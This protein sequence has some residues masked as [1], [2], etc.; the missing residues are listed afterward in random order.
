[1]GTREWTGTGYAWPRALVVMLLSI[2]C[3]T[4]LAASLDVKV[5]GMAPDGSATEIRDYRWTIE[6]DL[7]KASVP[8]QHATRDNY[9][10]STHT[11][12][13]PLVATGKM[14]ASGPV[15]GNDCSDPASLAC[16][17]P[18]RKYMPLPD[19]GALDPAGR[20]YISVLP[21]DGYAMGGA[22]I[23]PGDTSVTVYVNKYPL[24]AAQLSVFVFNDNSPLN[25]AP[26]LPQEQGLAGFNIL[27]TE[28][29]G[30]YGA[31]GGQVTQDA[32]GNPLG[33]TYKT[34][35]SSGE[36]RVDQYCY[37]A[38]GKPVVAV[39]GTG[40]IRSGAD[41]VAVIRNLYPAKYTVQVIP[42]AGTDWKQTSTIEGTKGDD[43]WVKNGE[44]TFFQEYGPPGHHVFTGF[45]HAGILARNGNTPVL[46]GATSITGRVVSIH[47]ARPPDYSFHNGAPIEKCWVG[48]NESTGTRRALYATACNPD[49]TFTIPKVPPGTWELVVWDEPMDVII[50]SAPVTV[51]ANTPTVN[52]GDVPVFRW[53]GRYEGR[54]FFDTN[55]DGFPDANETAGLPNQVMNI[56]FRDGSIYQSQITNSKGEFVFT[57]VFP[58]FNWMIA[59]V[60]YGRF[61]ATGAT[62][63]T[64]AGGPVAPHNGWTA[65]SWGKL[66]PQTQTCD[67][68]DV[69]ANTAGSA[70]LCT[71]VGQTK[72]YRVEHGVVLLEGMQLFLGQTNHIEFGKKQYTGAENGGIAG[73]VQYGITR[74]EDDPKYATAENWEPGVPRVQV[75]LYLDCDGDGKPDKPSPAGDGTCAADGLS[76]NGYVYDPPDVDNYPFCWSDPASCGLS[77]PTRGPEDVKRSATGGDAF[78]YGDVFR[79]GLDP[80]TGAPYVGLSTSDAWDDNVPTGCPGDPYLVPYGP[81]AGLPLDCYDG[82][83]NW[84]Q[85]RP[86]VFD[87]GYAFGSVAGQDNLPNVKYIVEV[88]APPGYIHQ[89][90]GDKN[91]VFGDNLT[92]TPQAEPF[93]CVGQVLPVPQ[94]LT[95]FPEQQIPNPNYKRP[96]QTWNKC[97]MKQ[98]DMQPGRNPAP[99]FFLFTEVPVA[100]HGV[101]FILD[102][103]SSEFDVNA[104]TFGEKHA[105]PHLPVSVQD[106]TGR[107]IGRVY[108]DEF[109]LFNYLV[110]STFTINPPFPSGVSPS[111]LTA[112]MNSP[113]PIPDPSGATNADGSPKLIMDPW[114]DRRYSQFCYTFQY[115]PGKTTYLDTPV[116]PVAAFPGPAQN[117]VDCEF[118]DGVPMIYSV[119]GNNNSGPWVAGSGTDRRLTIVSAGSAVEVLNPYYDPADP[120]SQRTIRRDF[121]FGPDGVTGNSVTLGNTVLPVLSW[122]NDLITVSVPANAQ[123]G[124]L[125]VTRAGVASPVGITVT[126]GGTA[127]KYVPAGGSIQAVIDAPSTNDGDLVIVPPGIYT[128]P[129]IMDKKIRLQGWGAMSTMLNVVKSA[130][131]TL[132]NWRSLLA[133]KIDARPASPP[134]IDPDTGLNTIV[135]GPNRTFD[136]LPGQNLGISLSNNEPL[137]FGAEEAPG[138][139]VVGKTSAN[140]SG[141]GH[142]NATNPARID[143]LSI[144]G[145]DTGGGILVS[146]YGRNV[147]ISNNRIFGNAG[148]YGGGI[149]IGHSELLDANNVGYG[150]YTDSVDPNANIH[151]NWVAQ[152]GG[153]ES[154]VGGGISLG[155]GA[156]NYQVT[157]NYVCGNFTLGD[158]GGI[159]QRG[160]ADGGVIA[161][162]DILFNQTY[163]QSANPTGGGIF[164]GGAPAPDA[165]GMS[166]G[167]GS[168]TITRNLVQGNNAG[169]GVGGGIRLAQVNGLDVTR[170]PNNINSWNRVTLTNNIIVDNVAGASA[171]GVSLVDALRVT[172]VNN[173]VAFN[174]TTAT[175]QQA[176][177][178]PGANASQPQPAGLVSEA[179]SP[180]LLAA[181]SSGLRSQH[182]FSNPSLVNNIFWQNRAFC[183]AITGTGPGQFGLFDPTTTGQCNSAS[184]AGT[185]PVYVDLAVLGTARAGNFANGY[186]GTGVDKLTPDH[187]ILTDLR[188]P[189]G[190]DNNH[191]NLAKD[192]LLVAP[193]AN[194]NRKPAP[195]IPGFSTTID[196]AATSDEGGNFIDVRYGPLTP[197]NCLNPDGTVKSPQSAA[198]CTLF[199]D[200]HILAG[201]PAVKAGLSRTALNGVPDV[202]FDGDRRTANAIDIGADQLAGSAPP[203][204]VTLPTL[205]LLDNFNRANANTLGSSWQQL[206]LAGSA[207]L[208]VNTQ[209]ATANTAG[210]AFWS[211]NFGASQGAGF[212]VTGTPPDGTALLLKGSGAF[213][214][215]TYTSY[216]QVRLA[217]GAVVVETTVT[218]GLA[219]SNQQTAATGVTWATGEIF[220]AMCDAAG[221]V[222]VWKVGAD[223]TTTQLLG[224]VTLP[225]TGTSAFVT[226]GG[227]TGMRLVPNGPVDDYRAGNVQ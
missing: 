224:Q 178:N 182:Q 179:T 34:I 87:G 90:N 45:T 171:G 184:P 123:S 109:G 30:T 164:I 66:T 157:Q 151:H 42:P 195:F 106:W 216:I 31:S 48:L 53:F 15:M 210:T 188:G 141:N 226:G 183:W 4:A 84:N 28:A 104:P 193:Y 187:S 25:G 133:R 92:P 6:R 73:I 174:D 24:P 82:L 17:D 180:A 63:V 20:Y 70:N 168:V 101:G 206:V 91:V 47:N 222:T 147:Q 132:K 212:T 223:G 136:L 170:A 220:A 154:G 186:T 198:N 203:P 75:N 129:L 149:R 189:G 52:L 143:G 10:F 5:M 22:M 152:N 58:F 111:M 124:Q 99:N 64:D 156:S 200:Y 60:D 137:L 51:P 142:F 138:V 94:F 3:G 146:G 211:G 32:F 57:E 194:G 14:T 40:I 44:P 93:P 125:T 150:G 29:G 221:T 227:R 76:S 120:G 96:G 18:D 107:E 105:P 33:T 114:F 50:A 37:G 110:P 163:N 122:S 207:S 103:L 153:T 72:P 202:D 79:W 158:G 190:Y 119:T 160:L 199:G 11:S 7:T 71:S 115:L 16:L 181:M 68:G 80:D 49:S 56:R 113:G 134:V 127:P 117:P 144:T 43:A 77:E 214:L 97:D 65:P 131:A 27:L 225:A 165:T 126:V 100:G 140:G 55:G 213:V 173:T 121:G 88:V 69:A 89:G 145:S 172:A 192:P 98:V 135:A 176:F 108:A 204:P 161:D 196:T 102:D 54:V 9:A 197:W 167:S 116:V 1:M 81:Q 74:A 162:N 38:D 201:S 21:G 62:I 46:N 39:R 112:C 61:K 128:A 139:L 67:A 78:G 12:H 166:A 191:A 13:M 185:N 175:S 83:R 177:A 159:G 19:L 155:N 86:A 205:P 219:F 2:A 118:G 36:T 217:G 59:E 41:G 169:A 218:G 35:C 26:D 208:R 209:R 148:T 85:V 8:G 130:S 95:L 23:K 215:G